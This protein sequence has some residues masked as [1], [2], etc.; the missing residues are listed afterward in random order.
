MEIEFYICPMDREE[1]SIPEKSK[2]HLD[3]A[4]RDLD[5]WKKHLIQVLEDSP[6]AER[7]FLRWKV[8]KPSDD[9]YYMWVEVEEGGLEAGE[10]EV[11]VDTPKYNKGS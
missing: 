2:S 10:L 6:S 3:G 11:G 1:V 9:D 5:L 4:A 7:K 8:S